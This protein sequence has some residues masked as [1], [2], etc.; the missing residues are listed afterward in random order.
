MTKVQTVSQALAGSRFGLSAHEIADLTGLDACEV[1]AVLL[2]LEGDGQAV[3]RAVG[4]DIVWSAVAAP[5][6]HVASHE[7]AQSSPA[8][9]PQATLLPP[10]A[11]HLHLDL[12]DGAV[13]LAFPDLRTLRD[14]IND[15]TTRSIQ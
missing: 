3:K 11:G 13:R 14:F 1:S 4:R 9:P 12:A 6:L 15:L 7:E 8:A 10:I 2:R 5:K